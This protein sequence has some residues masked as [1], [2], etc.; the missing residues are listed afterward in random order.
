M[1][2]ALCAGVASAWRSTPADH[3]RVE[4]G[5]LPVLTV[6]LSDLHSHCHLLPYGADGFLVNSFETGSAPAF[7]KKLGLHDENGVSISGARLSVH[8]VLVAPP[9]E[10]CR[11]LVLTSSS[12]DEISVLVK[13][14]R[15]LRRKPVS[16]A[17]EAERAKGTAR[18]PG[19]GRAFRRIPEETLLQESDQAR[20]ENVQVAKKGRLEAKAVTHRNTRPA[21]RSKPQFTSQE[22]AAAT[23]MGTTR[24]DEID[25][26][27]SRRPSTKRPLTEQKAAAAELYDSDFVPSD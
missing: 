22:A 19:N 4:D 21:P 23:A 8:D 15:E 14:R 3:S 6:V 11:D 18:Q 2:K 5:P 27:S 20:P 26:A 24:T 16:A 7:F 13:T 25:A 9:G 12:T 17:A 10:L 1:N